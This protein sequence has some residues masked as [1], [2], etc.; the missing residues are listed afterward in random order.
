MIGLVPDTDNQV[1]RLTEERLNKLH[2]LIVECWL[3]PKKQ[4]YTPKEGAK[5]MGQL[6]SCMQAN[7]WMNTPM[8][9]FQSLVKEALGEARKKLKTN[10]RVYQAAKQRVRTSAGLFNINEADMHESMARQ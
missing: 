9:R 10:R 6:I 4:E 2:R 5:L 3:K 1:L 8:L 7:A